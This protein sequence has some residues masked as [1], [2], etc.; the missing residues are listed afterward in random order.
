[1][2]EIQIVFT[3]VN[4]LDVIESAV[5]SVLRQSFGEWELT[6]VDDGSTDG[7]RARLDGLDPRI[8]Y[9]EQANQGVYAARNT[10]LMVAR[11]RFV[12]FLDS[13]EAAGRDALPPTK[14]ASLPTCAGVT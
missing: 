10:G 5:S 3:A 12:T 11:G 6:V 13:D 14:A 2:P 9:I 4:R 8:R 1:M 7:T